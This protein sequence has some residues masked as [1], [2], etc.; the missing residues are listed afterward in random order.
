MEPPRRYR[1]GRPL[2]Q[3]CHCERRAGVEQPHGADLS[4]DHG[5]TILASELCRGGLAEADASAAEWK[6]A[7]LKTSM[8]EIDGHVDTR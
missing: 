7:L 5:G 3:R 8:T 2:G 4:L 1:A 6:A